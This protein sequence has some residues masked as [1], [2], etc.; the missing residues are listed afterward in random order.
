MRLI[1]TFLF[2]LVFF[3]SLSET[4]A[5]YRNRLKEL[6]GLYGMTAYTYF[7]SANR[8]VYSVDA[9]VTEKGK[10]FLST[11]IYYSEEYFDVSLG[12]NY[13]IAKN[14]ELFAGVSPYTQLY[15]FIGNRISGFGDSYIGLKYKFHES[16]YFL[17]S[18]QFLVKLPTASSKSQ[19]GTGKVDLNFGVAESFYIDRFG[20]DLGVELNFL[21][22]RDI[23]SSIRFPVFT[24]AVIDSI[25]AVYNYKYEPEFK[26][27]A[28]P[29]YSITEKLYSYLG[30]NFSRNLRLNYN[31]TGLYGGLG[32]SLSEKAGLGIGV[33]NDILLG[34]YWIFSSNF[35]ITL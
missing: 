15:S 26:I 14:L 17:H 32:Y 19:L 5:Q 27:S 10:V 13:G 12:I 30:F 33:S 20:F 16:N 9:Y 24:P 29:S 1:T 34:G 25:N 18:F 7:L 28:G 22:R 23:P 11:G 6:T 4:S 8:P 31:S 35:Y 3:G 2:L 21:R